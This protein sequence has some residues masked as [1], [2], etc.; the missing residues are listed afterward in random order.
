M[1]GLSPLRLRRRHQSGGLKQPELCKGCD[2]IV[3][4]DFF[5]DFP[6]DHFENGRAGEA[7]LA[8]KSESKEL[9]RVPSGR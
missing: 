4:A 8:F 3:E 5:D 7:H 9:S 6:I 2:A 1:Q